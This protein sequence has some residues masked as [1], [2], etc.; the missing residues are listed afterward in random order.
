MYS[1]K[2]LLIFVGENCLQKKIRLT[3]NS[4]AQCQYFNLVATCFDPRLNSTMF[5][6]LYPF[7]DLRF[8]YK[9][10]QNPQNLSVLY[11]VKE[12]NLNGRPFKILIPAMAKDPEVERNNMWDAFGDGLE[13]YQIILDKFNASS[14]II[15]EKYNPFPYLHNALD[16][17]F[18]LSGFYETFLY[19]NISLSFDFTYPV[20]SIEV[21]ILV[22]I[23][24]E[25]FNLRVLINSFA[26]RP[27]IVF[28]V[29]F[30]LWMV[31]A[32][33]VFNRTTSANDLILSIIQVI[34]QGS[35]TITANNSIQT[36]LLFTISAA[37][38]FY[39]NI[40][41]TLLIVLLLAPPEPY[42][43]QTISEVIA[44]NFTIYSL[45]WMN[46]TLTLANVLPELT[47]HMTVLSQEEF[48]ELILNWFRLLDNECFIGDHFSMQKLYQA[49]NYPKG[50]KLYA[51]PEFIYMAPLG[52]MFK[53]DSAFTH[54]VDSILGRLF[55]AGI[56]NKIIKSQFRHIVPVELLENPP[57]F[58]D[59]LDVVF[60]ILA[61]LLLLSCLVFLG[62][63]VVFRAFC[64][65]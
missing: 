49:A 20:K 52:K 1:S 53:K 63:I 3:L 51:V 46:S 62:E 23:K 25:K 9:T 22:P 58:V 56:I 21:F 29:F 15:N 26:R 60:L 32:K 44:N 6:T 19:E 64:V 34:F 43:F 48:G 31:L 47:N 65:Q 4:L 59:Q 61:G 45:E 18:A 10:V 14:F 12:K 35:S 24:Q 5:M 2:M 13:I 7:N 50:I 28:W 30:G 57:L 16:A 39:I 55:E 17:N 11:E 40:V 41:Q 27:F 8:T 42:Q 37:S 36:L 33:A 54:V 38:F